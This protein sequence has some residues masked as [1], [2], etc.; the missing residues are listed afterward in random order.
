MNVNM[1][2]NMLGNILGNMMG[3]MLGNKLDN[4]LGNIKRLQD[5]LKGKKLEVPSLDWSRLLMG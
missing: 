3:N 2:V 5:L 4:M 1:L